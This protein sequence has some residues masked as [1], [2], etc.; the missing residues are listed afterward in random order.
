LNSTAAVKPPVKGCASTACSQ[1]AAANSQPLGHRRALFTAPVLTTADGYNVYR[2][3]E[4]GVAY[5]AV[6]DLAAGELD[7]LVTLFRTTP[8]EQ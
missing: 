6:S 1:L 7:T 5:W 8:P 2:W 4:G 3:S